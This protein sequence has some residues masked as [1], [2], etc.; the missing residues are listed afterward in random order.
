MWDLS[1]IDI[2]LWGIAGKYLAIP[3]YQLL[4]RKAAR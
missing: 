4:V 3:I 2:A 1:A